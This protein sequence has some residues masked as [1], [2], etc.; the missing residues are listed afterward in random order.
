MRWRELWQFIIH[1][2]YYVSNRV[3][4]LLDNKRLKNLHRTSLIL[5]KA[6]MN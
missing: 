5:E 2:T 6:L 4:N 1:N 3:M